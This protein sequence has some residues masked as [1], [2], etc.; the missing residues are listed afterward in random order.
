MLRISRQTV[1]SVGVSTTGAE[2]GSICV[3]L[4]S[5][6]F[7]SFHKREDVACISLLGL[8]LQ[9]SADWVVLYFLIILEARSLESRCQ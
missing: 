1:G 7:L 3:F 4:T 5:L 2:K 8:P 6:D 9:S